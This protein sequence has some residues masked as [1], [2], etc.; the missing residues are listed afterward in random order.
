MK[1]IDNPSLPI[2]NRKTTNIDF[3][4]KINLYVN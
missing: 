3:D 4:E 1:N 2:R